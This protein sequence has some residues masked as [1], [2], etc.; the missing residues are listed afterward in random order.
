MCK[1][2]RRFCPALL[3]HTSRVPAPRG[4]ASPPGRRRR[5]RRWRRRTRYLMTMYCSRRATSALST[6]FPISRRNCSID[7]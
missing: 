2:V 4:R 7:V 5:R 6:Y 1:C 3:R